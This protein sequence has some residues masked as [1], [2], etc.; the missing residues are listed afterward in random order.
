MGWDSPVY[1]WMWTTSQPVLW[2]L[3]LLILIE[4]HVHTLG[5]ERIGRNATLYLIALSCSIA[6]V[7]FGF[8]DSIRPGNF[9]IR[10]EQ[11]IYLILCGVEAVLIILSLKDP[12]RRMERNDAI[13]YAVF[14]ILAAAHVGVIELRNILGWAL[15]RTARYEIM[16]GLYAGLPIL[17][18]VGFRRYITGV[19]W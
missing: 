3:L 6:L 7:A 2:L 16:A 4:C 19:K 17:G 12:T 18:A 10:S 15:G 1:A 9:W 14:G 8:S 13:V 11:S 5:L